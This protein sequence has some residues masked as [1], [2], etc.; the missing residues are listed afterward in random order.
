MNPLRHHA[1]RGDDLRLGRPRKSSG[2]IALSPAVSPNAAT[3][4]NVDERCR[5]LNASRSTLDRQMKA[6]IGRTPKEEIL[7]VR[8]REV[9]RL[10]RETDLTVEAIAGQTGFAYSHYLQSAFKSEYGQTPGEFRQV[11]LF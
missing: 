7:R 8:F 9:E 6:A 4:L 2:L 1:K 3:G 11:N 5:K 10:L